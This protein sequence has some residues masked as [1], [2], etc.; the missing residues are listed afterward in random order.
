MQ[1][2]GSHVREMTER[3]VPEANPGDRPKDQGD[4]QRDQGEC[5][6]PENEGSHRRSFF[7]ESMNAI[8]AGVSKL[9]HLGDGSDRLWPLEPRSSYCF[10]S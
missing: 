7:A 8:P 2:A 5:E 4:G 3:S 9:P 1:T 6:A 10:L